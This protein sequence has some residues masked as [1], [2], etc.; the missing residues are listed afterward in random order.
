MKPAMSHM[1]QAGD[2][3]SL[4]V[5]PGAAG[6][7]PPGARFTVEPHGDVVILR[8]EPSAAEEWWATTTP[9][10][11]VAWLA[12]WIASRPSSPAPPSEA[13]H[14]DSIYEDLW[15]DLVVSNPNP[16]SEHL[17]AHPRRA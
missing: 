15:L 3:G 11:R 8:R 7:V 10:Q 9:S 1:I 2:D 17:P 13:T 6:P 4:L 14:R 12:E 16:I 5:P